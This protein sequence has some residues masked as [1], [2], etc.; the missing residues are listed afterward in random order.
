[1]FIQDHI[2]LTLE[3]IHKLSGF[4]SVQQYLK[5]NNHEGN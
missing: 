5:R 1:M 3:N 2:F 4:F